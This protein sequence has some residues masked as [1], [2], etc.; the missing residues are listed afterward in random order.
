[1]AADELG[2]LLFTLGVA[3][4][5]T[6]LILPPGIALGLLLARRHF[7]GKVALETLVTLPL[8]LPPVATGLVLLRLFGR[9][10]GIGTALERVGLEV[11]FTWRGVVIAMAVMAL[12]LLVRGARVAFEAVPPQL[13][14]A[15]RS[16]GASS[17]RVFFRVTLPLAGRGIIGGA[18]LAFAR[19]VGEFGATIL[20]AGNL[21]GRTTVLST[22]IFQAVETG[23]DPRALR[24]LAGAVV[25]AFGAV[26]ASEALLRRKGPRHP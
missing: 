22:A 19:A 23:E 8:V 15:A 9:R 7:P 2:I 18:L 24:L 6:L 5:A 10:G 14:E 26:A 12:P 16:I 13:E 17:R 21:P 1:M 25:L 3:A 4:I 11:V 20:V